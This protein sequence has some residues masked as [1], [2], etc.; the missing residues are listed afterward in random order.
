MHGFELLFEG[1]IILVA[2]IAVVYVFQRLKAGP[3]LGYLAAGVLIG[4]HALRLVSHVESIQTLAEFGVVFLLFI[5]GL[6]LSFRRLATMRSEVFG[7]GSAQVLLTAALIGAAVA[8]LG[9]AWKAAI[10]IGFGVALSS[11]AVVLQ[12]LSER[13]EMSGRMGRTSFSM[14]LLQDLAIIP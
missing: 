6:E 7:L 13:G 3:V 2:A 11:T 8:A 14:L 9:I 4:P 12:L 1:V 5:V 10:V